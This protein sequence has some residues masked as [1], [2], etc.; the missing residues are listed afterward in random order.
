MRWLEWLGVTGTGKVLEVG[1]PAPDVATLDHDGRTV[2]LSDFYKSSYTLI[3]F[4]PKAD[5]FGCTIQACKL[6]D[7]V[8]ELRIRDVRVLGVSTDSPEAL[9]HFRE[10]YHLPFAL[11]ADPQGTL[12][13]AFGVTF[14][15]GMARRQT[16][17]VK[18]GKIVWRDL[19]A[20]PTRAVVDLIAVI[21]KLNKTP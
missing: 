6:R 10:K 11:L 20:A 7:A 15:F 18:G 14:I 12:A 19:Q 16:F 4:Y 13:R 17:L 2:R 1:D 8:D 3:Y 21:G 5:T 9:Q